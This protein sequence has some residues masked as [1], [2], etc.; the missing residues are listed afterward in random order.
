MLVDVLV[1]ELVDV[2]V[3]VVVVNEVLVVVEV[4][5]AIEVLVVVVVQYEIPSTLSAYVPLLPR[6][7]DT[8]S[9]R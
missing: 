6:P 5:M 1:E 9:T 3:E 2:L 8:T 7:A 4:V